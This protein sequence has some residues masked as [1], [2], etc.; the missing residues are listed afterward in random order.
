MVGSAAIAHTKFRVPRVPNATI[1]RNALLARLDAATD[2]P[3]SLVV[4]APGSGKTALLAQWVEALDSPVAWMSCDR[5]DA[6]AVGYWRNLAT[7]VGL[8]WSDAALT[9]AELAD[10]DSD[11]EIAVGIVNQLEELDQPG[12]IVIDDFHM[13]APDPAVMKAFVSALPPPIRL[14][15]G[16]RCDPPF[17]VGR[18]RLQGRLLELRQAELRFTTA[19]ARQLLADL[20]VEV[21]GPQLEQI[22]E[23]TEGWA[24]AVHLAGL[25]VRGHDDPEGLLHGLGETDRSLVDFLMNEVIE[26][27]PPDIV[28]FLTVTA[29][30]ET[31]DAELCDAVRGRDD[32]ADMLRRAG[33]AN[34][35]L[36]EADPASGWYRYHHLFGQFLRGRLR[37]VR[38]ERAT[39]IHRAA[40]EAY[41]HRGELMA[42]VDHSMQAGDTETALA[43]L[44]AY[45]T[46]TWS[47]E[48][49]TAGAATALAWLQEHGAVHL[50]HSPQSVLGCTVMLNAI[51]RGGDAEPWLRQ[52][53]ALEPD[54]DHDTRF[55][56][57][58]AWSF[59]RLQHGDPVAA[60][61]RARRAEDVLDD[62][63][64]ST[65]W[66]QALPYVL[67]Q[68]QL[69]L[70][71]LDGADAILESAHV[72]PTQSPVA[73][74]V[75]LPGL[76]SR[77]Q[78]VRGELTDAERLA[79][80][81]LA[82]ADQ[83]GLDDTNFG[84]A[85]PHLS[86][87]DVA[88]ERDMLDEA[89]THA[90]RV[91]RI[92]EGGRR[93]PLEVLAHL[94]LALTASAR[95]DH[96]AAV[97]AI[98]QARAVLPHATRPVVAHID[99]VDAR[100]ALE[101]GDRRTAAALADRLPRSPAAALLAARVQLAAEKPVA[102]LEI[103]R[104]SIGAGGSTRR[105][106]IEHSLLSARAARDSRAAD[107]HE[108]MRR[109]LELAAP[110]G[111]RRSIV[112]E[113]P[114]VWELLAALP[115]H[116]VVGDYVADLLDS[117]HRVVPAPRPA[118]DDRLVEPLSDRERT[119]LRYL[120]SHLTCTEIARELYL[121]VN[122]VRSHVKAI[123]RKLGV[124]SRAQAVD[125]GRALGAT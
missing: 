91:M 125:R 18:L 94:E 45:T 15:L 46:R 85:E 58:G 68:A 28:E 32:S 39:A 35:F 3:L 83:L 69:W 40:A 14:V 56:L 70:D 19:E 111:F 52:V 123:Y 67:V 10:S 102:A 54:L 121:S 82:A 11:D 12:A 30:L 74:R 65:P 114:A 87:A 118:A 43:E 98:A 16:G 51:G 92:A 100:L 4:A 107:P 2:C 77:V 60:L 53:D 88:F 42:A 44:E 80:S 48:D 38:P 23:I 20:G 97:D 93:P 84:L 17:P 109:A 72:D 110:V 71:D 108:P 9:A 76:A 95:G 112:A 117:A 37:A 25:W 78:V 41:T 103:L 57:H 120:A 90:E 62:G 105:L 99:Q 24:A 73:S 116:G 66:L 63:P 104:E 22:I 96:Q 55:V 26:L 124:N 13:A 21:S 64:V 47:L 29:E 106:E 33:A 122:T 31:F 115:A 101:R 113:G 34:L 36:V 5:T 1:R 81:A 86:L 119:V 7:A 61:D 49:R 79:T 50:E 75:R 89:E 6:D 8:A 27:Q 59:D